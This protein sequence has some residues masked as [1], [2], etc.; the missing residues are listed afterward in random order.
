MAITAA[1]INKLRQMTGAGM[2]DCKKALEEANGDYEKAQEII[3]KKGQLVAAKRA[4]REATEG[5]VLAK[6]SADGTFGAL[7]VVCCETDFVGKNEA[8]VQFGTSINDLAVSQKPG[9]IDA[10]K[11]LKLGNLTVGE[12]VLEKV[13]VIGEKIDL[14]V[15]KKIE[16]GYVVAYIHPGNKL[17]TMVGFNKKL[18]DVQIGKDIAMQIAAMN[19]VAVDKENVS[20]EVVAKEKEIAMEQTRLDKKN[21]GKPANIVEKIAEGRLE[22]FFKENTLL[23]QEFIKD[24]KLTVGQ[25]LKNIDKD[26]KVT[27]FERYTLNA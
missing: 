4:D 11:Q 15:Y 8:F 26:L 9:D 24:S 3:R 21:E 14:I 5:V 23:N 10:L 19:P 20:A 1:E 12:A 16:A 13:G 18:S 25:Y 2:M 7:T 6:T 22:K 17:A 27:G